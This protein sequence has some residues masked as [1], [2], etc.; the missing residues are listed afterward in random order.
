M[1]AIPDD[2]GD[3]DP[4]PT[5]SYFKDRAN[6]KLDE[7]VRNHG[8][9][10]SSADLV[11]RIAP[12]VFSPGEDQ[13]KTKSDAI[14]EQER[15]AENQEPASYLPKIAPDATSLSAAF[16][17]MKDT[18]FYDKDAEDKIAEENRKRKLERE[19]KEETQEKKSDKVIF[20][21]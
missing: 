21:N 17:Y 11:S 2:S 16:S 4:A 12:P 13:D 3:E 10:A 8:L 19:P 5:K 6:V 20:L 7:S 18:E 15:P 1:Y 9:S 14:V